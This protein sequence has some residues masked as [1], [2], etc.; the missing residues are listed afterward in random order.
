[1]RGPPGPHAETVILRHG[2]PVLLLPLRQSGLLGDL[3]GFLLRLLALALGRFEVVP[4]GDHLHLVEDHPVGPGRRVVEYHDIAVHP[5]DQL[6]AGRQLGDGD[7]LILFFT[8]TVLQVVPGD[9]RGG[10]KAT[11][12]PNGGRCRHTAV[13]TSG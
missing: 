8:V 2:R 11:G 13:S 10:M 3:V 7:D 4:V 6:R 1:M 12:Y 5:E 9:G